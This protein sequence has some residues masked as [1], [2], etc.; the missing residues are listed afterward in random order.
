MVAR[1]G[2]G[3]R[4]TIWLPLPER[5]PYRL[6]IRMDPL[7]F[8]E[9]PPQRVRVFVDR[10]IIGVFTLDW[11]PERVGAYTV[12]IPAGLV[13]AGRTRL[14]LM[15]DHVRPLDKIDAF[16]ELPRSLAAGFRLWY[17]RLTPL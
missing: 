6:V 9:A 8:E 14:E 1:L 13:P 12:D 2:T 3:V 15:P 5:R 17:V 4:S 7:P 16:P 11:N 10:H